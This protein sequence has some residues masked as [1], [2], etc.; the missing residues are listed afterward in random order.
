MSIEKLSCGILGKALSMAVMLSAFTLHAVELRRDFANLANQYRRGQIDNVAEQI[1]RLQANSD[2][3]R[4]FIL[5][6][7]A[8]LK[9]AM[10]ESTS[11]HQQNIS[12]YPSTYHGQLSMLEVAK[13]QILE[14]DLASAKALMRRI[15]HPDIQERLYWQAVCAFQLEEYEESAGFA[16]NYIRQGSSGDYFE[17]A[18]Y[19]L[20]DAQSQQNRH[21]NSV[22]TLNRLR[23]ISSYPTDEQYFYYRLG[24][25]QERSGSTRDALNS[26][27]RAYEM[28]KFTQTAY[29]VE[30]RLFAMRARVGS[31]LDI[32]FLYPY[33]VI[34]DST[35]TSSSAPVVT[36]PPGNTP[37]PAIQNSPLRISGRPNRGIFLQAGRFSVEANA[38]SR[39]NEIR[40]R[41]MPCSYFEEQQGGRATWV[42]MSGPF[43]STTASEQ[44]RQTLASS[45]IDCFVVRY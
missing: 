19:L 3:E 9:A 39:A 2:E 42:V 41:N 31:S 15:T 5:Y 14:H 24:Y 40:A 30:D 12:R 35:A 33:T 37:D 25:A 1:L 23:G 45:N 32:S 22:S 44:A 7:G 13:S 11:L 27:Q 4:A 10:T 26:Y 17:P 29:M 34:E 20:A 18:Y 21:S 8:M 43:D 38:I 6:Y 28:N 36:N 16:E